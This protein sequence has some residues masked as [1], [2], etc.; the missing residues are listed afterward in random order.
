MEQ[1]EN[2]R[3][4]SDEDTHQTQ[5]LG[6]LKK[7]KKNQK[8]KGNYLHI[9]I[10]RGAEHDTPHHNSHNYTDKFPTSISHISTRLPH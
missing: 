2:N 3:K 6:R 8:Q 1:G 9:V 5:T 7:K 4:H 10:E